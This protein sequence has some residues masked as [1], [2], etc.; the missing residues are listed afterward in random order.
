MGGHYA[1]SSS[2]SFGR[3][4]RSLYLSDVPGESD[5][6]VNACVSPCRVVRLLCVVSE[7]NSEHSDDVTIGGLSL[8]EGLNKGVSFLD[9]GAC[10]ISGNIHSV[11]VSVAIK[12]LDS[13]H[14]V[15][16]LL[17]EASQDDREKM[18]TI[19]DT[20]RELTRVLGS[21]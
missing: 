19:A 4:V 7:S 1:L 17:K 5:L 3:A 2:T 12:S 6:A 9:R 16:D 20:L 18:M 8:N 11:E 13:G 15:R 10:L 21:Q 14:G